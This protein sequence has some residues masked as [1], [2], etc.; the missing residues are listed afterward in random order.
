MGREAQEA[1]LVKMRPGT[2]VGQVT[3]AIR[4]EAAK[5]GWE[6][7]G[8][9]VGHG[10]GLD[11]TESPTMFE[12]NESALEAGTTVILHS[13]FRLPNSGK[14]FI[15]LGDLCLVTDSGPELLMS[16]PRTPFVAGC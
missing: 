15:P 3:Q 11:Y 1:G 9:R 5:Y 12:S 2:P 16:F 10:I 8:G 7:E 4:K 13:G 6:I 14:L